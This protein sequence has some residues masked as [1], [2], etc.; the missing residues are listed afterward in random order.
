MTN[1]QTVLLFRDDP[2]VVGPANQV[3]TEKNLYK[4][5][6]ANI[7]ILEIMDKANNPIRICTPRFDSFF[8]EVE[9]PLDEMEIP[10]N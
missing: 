9:R 10:L 7:Q 1:A 6:N 5:Y 4:A 8:D 2:L 3:V